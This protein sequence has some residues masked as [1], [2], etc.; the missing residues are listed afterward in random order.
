MMMMKLVRPMNGLR[1]KN[2]S[3][4]VRPSSVVVTVTGSH[5]RGPGFDS[6]RGAI[7]RGTGVIRIVNFLSHT[8]D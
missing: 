3:E 1:V 6:R 5:F 4:K 7:L 2:K 8:M